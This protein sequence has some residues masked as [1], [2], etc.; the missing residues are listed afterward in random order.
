MTQLSLTTLLEGLQ[1]GG[2]IE[3]NIAEYMAI[4]KK[5]EHLSLLACTLLYKAGGEA[6][7]SEKEYNEIVE[8]FCRYTHDENKETGEHTFIMKER[9]EEDMQSPIPGEGLGDAEAT[10]IAMLASLFGGAVDDNNEPE[11]NE[12]GDLNGCAD[13][14][15]SDVA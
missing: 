9:T 13:A 4:M 11:K 12:S 5:I 10:V 14:N 6:T 2:K 1:N 3:L 7:V 8:K 15:D